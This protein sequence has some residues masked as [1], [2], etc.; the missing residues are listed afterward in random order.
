MV[1]SEGGRVMA[2][3]KII[4]NQAFETIMANLDKLSDDQL[5]SLEIKSNQE[6]YERSLNEFSDDFLG[7]LSGKLL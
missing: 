1:T 5:D 4:L 7:D 2:N 6:L 3:S